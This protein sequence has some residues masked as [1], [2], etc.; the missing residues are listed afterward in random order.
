MNHSP[1]A[2]FLVVVGMDKSPNTKQAHCYSPRQH[3]SCVKI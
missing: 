2:P 3:H 1:Y